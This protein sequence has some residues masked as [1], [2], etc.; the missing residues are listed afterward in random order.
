M[1]GLRQWG[2]VNLIHTPHAGRFVPRR[3]VALVVVLFFI[4]PR[5]GGAFRAALE[6]VVGVVLAVSFLDGFNDPSA[7]KT[8]VIVHGLIINPHAVYSQGEI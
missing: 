8:C 1:S 4:S 5:D 6:I 2:Q 7:V 3:G